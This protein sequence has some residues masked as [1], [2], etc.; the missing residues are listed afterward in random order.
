M[1]IV[2]EKIS[3]KG[4]PAREV[5]LRYTVHGPVIYEDT[6]RNRVVSLRTVALE[7][8]GA[9][10]L[11]ML[12]TARAK[13]WAEFA[14]PWHDSKRLPRTLRMQIETEISDLRSRALRQYVRT[15]PA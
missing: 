12:S 6:A 5:L 15:G 13:N 14:P 9:G 8:G 10:Y 11:S 1:E 3:V 2:K 7:A 4:A